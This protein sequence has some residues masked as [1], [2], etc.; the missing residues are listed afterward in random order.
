MRDR[1]TRSSSVSGTLRQRLMLVA[2]PELVT[3]LRQDCGNESFALSVDISEARSC[4][5]ELAGSPGNAALLMQGSRHI[6]C[7]RTVV[8]AAD[9]IQVLN[10]RV[11]EHL[12]TDY[13]AN[14]RNLAEVFR[15]PFLLEDERWS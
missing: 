11:V 2:G 5:A 6:R 13:V 14:R 15:D 1:T 4:T 8:G 12:R 3:I 7:S 9:C 10:G